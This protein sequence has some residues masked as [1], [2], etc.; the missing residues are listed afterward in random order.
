M[1]HA[2]ASCDELNSKMLLLLL[3]TDSFI[4]LDASL[5]VPFHIILFD[6]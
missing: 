5:V 4:I 1:D 6:H 3:F 2:Q